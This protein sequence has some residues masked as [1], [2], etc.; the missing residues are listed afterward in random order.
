MDNQGPRRS[1]DYQG[2]PAATLP[3]GIVVPQAPGPGTARILTSDY[4]IAPSDSFLKVDSTVGAVN[5]TLPDAAAFTRLA[6]IRVNGATNAVTVG[7]RPGQT[8]NGA[9]TYTVPLTVWSA[10]VFLSDG[11]NVYASPGM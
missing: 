4:S 10:V 2:T 6:V 11:K 8:V 7:A 9:S 5:L 1:V 3:G